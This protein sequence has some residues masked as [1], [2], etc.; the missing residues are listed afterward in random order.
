[1]MKNAFYFM[2]KVLFVLE[3][4]NF[5]PDLFLKYH[6]QNVVEKFVPD[7]FIKNKKSLDQQL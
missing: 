6:T 5:C 7:P 3:M 4:L 2:L 1:M